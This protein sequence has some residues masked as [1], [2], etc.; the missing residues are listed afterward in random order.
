MVIGCPGAG[1]STIARAI[2]LKTRLPLIHLDQ[3]YWRAGWTPTPKDDWIERL[4]QICSEPQWILDG[5]YHGSIARRLPFADTVIV[6]EQPRW[7]CIY[8]VL[9]RT[10][11]SLG[12][13]R[14][15]M[16]PG[17]PERLNLGFLSFIWTYHAKFQTD[18]QPLL[19]DAAARGTRVVTTRSQYDLFALIDLEDECNKL[20]ENPSLA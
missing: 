13:V 8:N 19:D 6:V 11:G 17:C 9:R 12:K 7:R 15:D 2:A 10:F 1:K 20:A 3:E 16:A 4:K 5:N 14:S 18:I